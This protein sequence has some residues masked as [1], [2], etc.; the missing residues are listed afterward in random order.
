MVSGSLNV[1][2]HAQSL[3]AK[4]QVDHPQEWIMAATYLSTSSS[5]QDDLSIEI[6]QRAL[7]ASPH[8]PNGWA[9]LS[10]LQSRNTRAFDDLAE[11]Y[12]QKSFEHCPFCSRRLLRWRFTFTLQHWEEVNEETRL[13]AFSGADFLRWWYLDYE[14]LNTVREAALSENIP[15]DD[16]RRLVNTPVR[17]NEIR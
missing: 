16:Y 11:R 4:A 2:Q 6:L 17:P 13:A 9:L 14:F 8:H 3:R 7:D 12:L 10:F 1:A 5:E 15:F